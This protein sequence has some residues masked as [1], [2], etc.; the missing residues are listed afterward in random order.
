VGRSVTIFFLVTA[1]FAAPAFGAT[2][3]APSARLHVLRERPAVVR[4]DRF[5]DGER[6]AVVLYTTRRWV[7]SATAN[8]QGTLTVT[9]PVALPDCGR[10]SLHA[11]G[12]KGSRAR[13][14]NVRNT[15]GDPT[16]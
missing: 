5:K 15:C 3:A 10:Y 4:G 11:F 8:G 12:S 14:L 2:K 7:R 6:V 1:A 16:Q 13:S 9:F